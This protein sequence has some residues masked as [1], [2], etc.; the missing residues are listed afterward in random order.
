MVNFI[1]ESGWVGFAE[2]AIFIL[3]YWLVWFIWRVLARWT[4]PRSHT[5]RAGEPSRKRTVI[6]RQR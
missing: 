6:N 1:R 3:R 4:V 5:P 2:A